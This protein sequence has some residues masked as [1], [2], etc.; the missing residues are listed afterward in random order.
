MTIRRF[1]LTAFSLLALVG[2]SSTAPTEFA[3]TQKDLDAKEIPLDSF[4]KVNLSARV[5]DVVNQ[6]TASENNTGIA[7]KVQPMPVDILS[8]YAAKKFRASGGA[9]TTRFVIKKGEFTVRPV[10]IK[11]EGWLFDSNSYKAELGTNL[12]VTLV[13][14]RPDGMTAHINATTQQTQQMPMESSADARRETYMELM[15]RAV[16]AIDNELSKELP[17]WFD[18]VVV[19]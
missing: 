14:S 17:K 5:F 9:V 6:D 16:Q 15:T 18:E 12:S 8:S 2:C 4:G 7:G 19:R 1:A 10:E 13:A 11:E 3:I